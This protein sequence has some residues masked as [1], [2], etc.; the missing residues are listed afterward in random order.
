[1]AKKSTSDTAKEEMVSA[2]E[3]LL[4][5]QDFEL[6]I[7]YNHLNQGVAQ[8]VENQA[9]VVSKLQGKIV[10]GLAKELTSQD[11]SLERVRTMILNGL[12]AHQA[13]TEFL[14]QQLAMKSGAIKIGDPLESA[15]IQEATRGAEMT[16]VGTLVLQVAQAAPWLERICLALERIADRMSPLEDAD[17][18]AGL[19]EEVVSDD[20]SEVN[21]VFPGYWG[22][23]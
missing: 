17:V 6:S 23:L 16:Q 10:K 13:D 7:P 21:T 2:L 8:V 18:D 20:T 9:K 1:M 11:N 3:E 12:N 15:L 22:P 14:L 5:Q 19:G 4:A